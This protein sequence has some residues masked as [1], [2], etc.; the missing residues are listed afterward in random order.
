[1]HFAIA[2]VGSLFSERLVLAVLD[3]VFVIPGGVAGCAGV[4]G[5][6][7][8]AG[9]GVTVPPELVLVLSTPPW[10]EHAPRP[11]VVEVVPSLQITLA[12]LSCACALAVNVI[13]VS[14]ANGSAANFLVCSI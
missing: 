13:S 9:A 12:A 11:V 5:A 3:G 14:R 8:V 2:P 6:G 1:L 10:C 4:A 7:L